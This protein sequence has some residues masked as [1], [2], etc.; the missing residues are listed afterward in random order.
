MSTP[1]RNPNNSEFDQEEGRTAPNVSHHPSD[2]LRDPPAVAGTSRRSPWT[3][4]EV[5]DTAATG[6]AGTAGNSGA[7]TARRS[8]ISNLQTR[9]RN[10]PG[11]YMLY[12]FSAGI[13]LTAAVWN[14]IEDVASA[15]N[16]SYTS[17]EAALKQSEETIEGLRNG[18]IPIDV[19]SGEGRSEGRDAYEEEDLVAR[20]LEG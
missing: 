8:F 6:Q 5:D 7:D 12:S 18:S 15:W 19:A 2:R 14:T 9:A 1:S 10:R 11:T 4:F 13:L 3:T 20:V 17:V 16:R